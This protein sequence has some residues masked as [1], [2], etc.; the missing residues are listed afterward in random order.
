M[1]NNGSSSNWT[2]PFY[3]NPND[4]RAFVPKRGEVSYLPWGSTVNVGS[5][6]GKLFLGATAG[7]VAWAMF[8]MVRDSRKGNNLL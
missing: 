1:E 6:E 3:N 5:I 7:L 8:G 4:S 2:G